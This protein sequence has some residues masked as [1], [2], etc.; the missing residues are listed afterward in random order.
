M[1][2]LWKVVL[3]WGILMVAFAAITG[4]VH[5]DEISLLGKVGFLGMFAVVVGG[6][7]LMEK[8]G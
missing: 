8:A 2:V 4:I 5:S 7:A 6:I 1:R 3:V